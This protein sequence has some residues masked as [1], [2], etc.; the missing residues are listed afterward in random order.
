MSPPSSNPPCLPACRL[1]ED[2]A[3]HPVQKE[4]MEKWSPVEKF[5]YKT[6]LGSPLKLWASVGHWAIWHFDLS[7]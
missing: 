1:V 7:K 6:F 5:L 3:W 2:T 4:T